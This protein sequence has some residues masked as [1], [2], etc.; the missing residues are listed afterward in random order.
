MGVA[1]GDYDNDGYLDLFVTSFGA[2]TLFTNNGNGT[3]TDVTREAGVSDALWSTSAAFV[4][5]D[6]D[7]DLDLFVANYLDFSPAVEQGLPRC[8]RRAR[9]LQSARVPTRSRIGSIT[10]TATADSRT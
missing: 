7:G 3:F 8:R 2:D 1:V 6:R 5:Y 9:L 4:D 10:T